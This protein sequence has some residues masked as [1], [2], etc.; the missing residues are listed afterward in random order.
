MG[1]STLASGR[2][3]LLDHQ[4]LDMEEVEDMAMVRIYYLLIGLFQ[5]IG[6]LIEFFF[7]H[8]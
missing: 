8:H 1:L 4:E 3:D 2:Q 6:G 7:L 5:K